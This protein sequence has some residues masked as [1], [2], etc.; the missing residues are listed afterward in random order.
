M[1]MKHLVL[2]TVLACLLAPAAYASADR[3]A[4]QA[5]SIRT[6]Q[7]EIRAGVEARSGRYKDLPAGTRSEL[8]AKQ[9]EV[10]RMID[11]KQ[12][13]DELDENQKV[14]V[15]NALEWIEAAINKADDERLVCERR[16]VLGSTR[17]ERVCKTV[18][19]MRDEREAARRSMD[20]HGGV[21]TN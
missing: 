3:K 12:S 10:L 11:G 9:S 14:E 7:A 16:A 21:K 2:A 18:A 5:E 1:S 17:K 8:L 15:F 6:Q 4:L 13:T 20:T 19:Q